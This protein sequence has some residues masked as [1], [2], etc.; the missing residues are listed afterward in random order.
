MLDPSVPRFSFARHGRKKVAFK[1]D[2]P[3]LLL[4]TCSNRG[5]MVCGMFTEPFCQSKVG[6]PIGVCALPCLLVGA[7]F[8]PHPL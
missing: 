2:L 3:R 8:L 5:P 6:I 1:S 4:P 7:S